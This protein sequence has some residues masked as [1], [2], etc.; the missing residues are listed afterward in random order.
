M[1]GPTR[2]TFIRVLDKWQRGGE[3]QILKDKFIFLLLNILI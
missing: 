3:I 2:E 1:I